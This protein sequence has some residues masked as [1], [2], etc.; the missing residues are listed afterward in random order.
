M[1]FLLKLIN[2]IRNIYYYRALG[3]LNISTIT[4]S[5]IADALAKHAKESAE[6]KGIKAHF[7]MDESG[8]LNLVNVELVSE[9]ASSAAEEEEGA[10][11]KLGSTISKFFS[12]LFSAF[13]LLTKDGHF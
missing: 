7:S 10:F 1:Y 2:L 5:G 3:N 4:L 9:K 11:S 12:G 8:I 13:M 6:S